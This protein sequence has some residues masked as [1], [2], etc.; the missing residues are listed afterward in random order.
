MRSCLTA[1]VQAANLLNVCAREARGED[2]LGTDPHRI[3]IV[4]VRLLAHL[5][6]W[7][8]AVSSA[9]SGIHE[10][11]GCGAAM[12]ELTNLLDVGSCKAR[13]E[14]AASCLGRISSVVG[15]VSLALIVGN[16]RIARV[17]ALLHFLDVR[18]GKAW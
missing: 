14:N 10:P 5:L 7:L 8:L 2:G 13:R 9:V 12:V 11:G 15:V 4:L 6:L 3:A 18:A 16:A 17:V 1:V